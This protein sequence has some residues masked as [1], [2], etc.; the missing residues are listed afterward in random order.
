[1]SPQNSP[2]ARKQASDILEKIKRRLDEL[3]DSCSDTIL[4]DLT[5]VSKRVDAMQVGTD[6]CSVNILGKKE[7]H[8]E[9]GSP[10][11]GAPYSWDVI[12]GKILLS[13]EVEQVLGAGFYQ[14]SVGHKWWMERIHPDD[15]ARVQVAIN[16]ALHGKVV[17][18]QLEYRMQ[19]SAGI[20]VFLRDKAYIL[21]YTDGKAMSVNGIIS[22]IKQNTRAEAKLILMN[23]ALAMKNISLRKTQEL[24]RIALANAP[25]AVFQTDLELRYTWMYS[26]YLGEIAEKL[27]GRRDDEVFKPESIA[28]FLDIKWQALKNREVIRRELL[29]DFGDQLHTLVVSVEPFYEAGDVICGVIGSFLDVTEQRRLEARDLENVFKL[30]VNR[31]LLENHDRES[32]QIARQIHDGPIQDLASLGFTIQLARE[33]SADSDISGVLE[34]LGDDVKSLVGE[35]RQVTNELRPAGL[36][37]FGLTNAIRACAADFEKHHPTV[38]V[39]LSLDRLINQ[40]PENVS[41]ALF[42]IFQECIANIARHAQ[43]SQVSI[44]LQ[45]EKEQVWLEVNDNGQGFDLPRSWADF[46]RR[47]CYGLVLMKERAE[48]VG[49]ELKI[50]SCLQEGTTVLATAR[51]RP[52]LAA[53]AVREAEESLLD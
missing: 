15:R 50:Q 52:A 32:Q 39:M 5:S 13:R 22:D 45:V 51:R 16:K 49:G 37:R 42:R 7:T 46:T 12:K 11:T 29:L 31:R 47:G 3:P 27:I 33:L 44:K 8:G 28:E 43:A 34:Q 26:P 1:M 35:L 20:W 53:P 48:S 17:E 4:P 2:P 41:L 23:Q 9:A 6:A 24:F 14:P 25:V 10:V 40:V 36:I 21:R 30:E 38:K 18:Y 19:H